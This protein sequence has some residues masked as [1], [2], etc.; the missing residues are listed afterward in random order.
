[1]ARTMMLKLATGMLRKD[2]GQDEEKA[3]SVE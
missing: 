1:M 3:G 2:C